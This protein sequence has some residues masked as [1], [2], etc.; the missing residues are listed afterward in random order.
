MP[1]FMEG[2]G[3]KEH[4]R[5]RLI[6]RIV[7]A[8]LTVAIL[9]TAGFF[10][11]RTW[12]EE[13][14]F[15]RFKDVLAKRDYEAGYRMWCTVEKPCPYYPM[16]K[17]QAD[18]GPASKYANLGAADVRHVDY[19]GNGVV[20][21]LAYT[22][23]DPIALWVEHSNGIMSFYPYQRCPGKHFQLGPFF[24]RLFGKSEKG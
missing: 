7:V 16:D 9:G 4:R 17:F 1:G 2:Y 10:Y 20:F 12:S 24:R 21:D 3:V 13:R 18:W 14:V 8:V 22:G 15:A 5:G 23:A 19:C 6:L 11:F